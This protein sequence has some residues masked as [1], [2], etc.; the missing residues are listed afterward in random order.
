[1][2]IQTRIVNGSH[3]EI[4]TGGGNSITQSAPTNFHQ[5]YTRKILTAT[6]SIDDFREVTAS[7]R[8]TLEQSD[9]AWK[10]PPQSFIDK[11][12]KACA[13]STKAD[14]FGKYNEDTGFFELN[15]II[16]IGYDEA[17][18]IWARSIHTVVFESR[19]YALSASGWAEANRYGQCRTY[20]PI[21]CGGGYSGADMTMVLR[22]NG[23]V[24]TVNFVSGYGNSLGNFI[25][26]Y[27]AFAHCEKLRKILCHIGIPYLDNNTF[28]NCESLEYLNI[29]MYV[30]SKSFGNLDLRWSPK[31]S[32]ESISRIIRQAT[33]QKQENSMTLTLH[34]DAYARVTDEL[35]AI[36]AEKNITIATTN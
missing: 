15:E 21:I 6:E 36:A 12:N 10:R 34:P 31:L 17:L 9:A 22:G 8:A 11:W 5:F 28:P 16:D 19:K 14:Y 20:F 18:Q 25:K 30:D 4:Y 29:S 35:F 33:L 13:Y 7:E 32:D 27:G 24:E 2:A 1:M 23:T 3:T 26:L